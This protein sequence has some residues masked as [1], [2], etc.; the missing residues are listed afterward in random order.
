GV[1]HALPRRAVHL[2]A[3]DTAVGANRDG[4]QQA[5]VELEVARRLRV[6]QVADALDLEAPVLDVAREAVLLGAR[7][8]EAALRP[9]LVG[10]HVLRDLRLEPHRLERPPPPLLR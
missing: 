8:D 3:L 5:A 10:V 1:K 6:V 7:A 9:L 4:E 2:D